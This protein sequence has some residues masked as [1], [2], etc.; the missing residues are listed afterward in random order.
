MG[1]ITC[2]TSSFIHDS[3][4]SRPIRELTVS[5]PRRKNMIR[6]SCSA[7]SFMRSMAD[8]F[9]SHLQVG[10]IPSL[11]LDP[12]LQVAEEIAFQLRNQA[13]LHNL[14]KDSPTFSF[15]IRA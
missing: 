1:R 6:K 2:P 3:S 8:D 11:V 10:S 9:R 12:G 5:L 13:R 14:R 15:V 7:T 4:C